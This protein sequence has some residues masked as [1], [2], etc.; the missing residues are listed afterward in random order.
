[1][2][3]DNK[4]EYLGDSVYAEFDGYGIILTTENGLPGDPNNTIYLEKPVYEALL[5]CI[6]K[7]NTS[8]KNEVRNEKP[9][10]N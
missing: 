5:Y 7:F 4:K 2:K 8:E 6:N 10:E 3:M 9:N 1:M